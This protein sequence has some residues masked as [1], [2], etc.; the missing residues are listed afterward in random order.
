[1]LS[2]NLKDYKN[3]VFFSFDSIGLNIMICLVT[4]CIVNYF[5]CRIV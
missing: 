3:M 4:N 2:N 5:F 1:M